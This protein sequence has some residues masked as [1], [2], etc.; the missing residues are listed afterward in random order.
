MDKNK[1]IAMVVGV[2]LSVA[3]AVFG[4]NYKAEVCAVPAV[5]VAK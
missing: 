5:E 2:L 1:L 3:G 4:Y